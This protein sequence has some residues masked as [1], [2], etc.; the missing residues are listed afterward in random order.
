VWAATLATAILTGGTQADMYVEEGGERVDVP[1]RMQVRGSGG[2]EAARPDVT[3]I[4]STVDEGTVTVVRAGG[5]ELTVARVVGSPLDGDCTLSG[6][7]GDS[8]EI[9]VLASLRRMNQEGRA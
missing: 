4:D 5:L 2:A 7:V 6:R 3:S 9:L 8:D 1:A